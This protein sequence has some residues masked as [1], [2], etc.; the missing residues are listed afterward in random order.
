VQLNYH[1]L[2]QLSAQLDNILVKA[3]FIESFCQQ[4]DELIISF[5]LENNDS[6]LIRAT[7]TSDFSCLSFPEEFQRSRK[8]SVNIFDSLSNARVK[9]IQQFENER[10]FSIHF[11][12]GSQLLFKMFGNRSNILLIPRN[13]ETTMFKSNF[14]KDK[15][16]NTEQ[17]DREINPRYEE[18]ILD[19]KY[20]ASF[21]TFGNSVKPWLQEN[22]Y[23]KC[24]LKEK[25]ELLLQLEKLLSQNAFFICKKGHKPVFSLLEST[26]CNSLSNDPIEAIN[27]F[28][29]HF[30]KTY[31]FEVRKATVLRTLEKTKKQIENYI[32][33]SEEKLL[34]LIGDTQPREIGDIIMANLHV[35]N[36]GQT[37]ITLFN[38]YTNSDI[39]IRL[40]K[41][42]SPQKN[43]ENYYR[44]GKNRKIELSSIENSVS[45][46]KGFLEKTSLL[47]EKVEACE[48]GK[49]L[50]TIVKEN[51]LVKSTK[52]QALNVPYKE[53]LIDGFRIWVGKNAK[54]NDELTLKYSFKEDLWLHA[55]DIPGSH[56]I[57]KYES[58]RPF[59]MSIIEKAAEIAAYYSKRKT[60][61]FAPVIYTP[62]KF[63]RKR[64]G[65]LPGQVVVDKEKVILVSP[66]NPSN[67]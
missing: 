53:F 5:K 6:F 67:T 42:L 38:F 22:G 30:S 62:S 46:K 15:E 51:E 48:S 50:N 21:P 8:N 54:H 49:T 16:I 24:T 39:L 47:I 10:A 7:L 26:D 37:E 33:K 9:S 17:L 58:N 55:K 2:K 4:K 35:F 12:S 64:K 60:D 28:Y 44:K 11:E 19:Q 23:E 1:F 31:Y 25:W 29:Q 14:P 32:N 63:V 59:N 27:S 66:K 36:P 45:S 56:L 41:K 34:S 40:N 20:N 57:I 43:A 61:S 13:G 18:F 3:T 52:K 65:S